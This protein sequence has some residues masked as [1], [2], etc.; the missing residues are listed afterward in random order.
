MAQKETSKKIKKKKWYPILANATFNNYEIGETIAES[1]NS[2]IGKSV[3]VSLMA[4]TQDMKT[5]NTKLRFK[6]KEAKDE[7]LYT[8]LVGYEIVTSSLKRLVHK[9]KDKIDDSFI[10]TTKDNVKIRVK[11]FIVTKSSTNRSVLKALRKQAYESL[12]DAAS[13]NTYDALLEN[14]L[15]EV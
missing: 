3:S 4:L 14:I 7:K 5:Q 2:M 13:K 8:D 15:K 6:I 11:P 1:A 10:L 12:A 9:N